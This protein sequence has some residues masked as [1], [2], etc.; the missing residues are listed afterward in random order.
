MIAAIL[1][2]V[3]SVITLRS[4]PLAADEPGLP[5]SLAEAIQMERADALPRT[6][7]YDT[8]SLG[9]TKPGDLLRQA[10]FRGY[11]VPSGARAVRIL[12]H[13]LNADGGD[14]ATSGVVLIPAGRP[15]T[16]GWPVIAWAHGTSGVARMCAPSLQK[17]MEYGEEGLMPMVRAG[18]AV[19]AT[20]YHGLGTE[21]PHE[22]IN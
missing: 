18:F 22:Y 17:D 5:H 10:P 7:F 8:P 16:G 12:Y 19:V 13:S 15:P 2:A 3:T 21:G 14:V 4:A 9:K 20:D 11:A 6:A 1:A